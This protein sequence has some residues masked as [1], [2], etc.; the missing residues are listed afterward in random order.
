M[1]PNPLSQLPGMG[2]GKDGGTRHATTPAGFSKKKLNFKKMK[3]QADIP[4]T[5]IIN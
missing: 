1:F 5:N 2:V 4:N 3:Y